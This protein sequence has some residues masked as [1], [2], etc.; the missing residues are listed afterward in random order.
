MS[1]R[2]SPQPPFGPPLDSPEPQPPSGPDSH[3]PQSPSEPKP[4]PEC[5]PQPPSEPPPP[6]T[7][8]ST[9]SGHR[10]SINHSPPEPTSEPVHGTPS[11]TR[12]ANQP[13]SSFTPIAPPCDP[14]R[15]PPVG[16]AIDVQ[17][18]H[19]SGPPT[20]PRSQRSAGS[21]VTTRSTA[22]R[23]LPTKL[24]ELDDSHCDPYFKAYNSRAIGDTPSIKLVHLNQATTENIFK[25][26]S[27][28]C[29]TCREFVHCRYIIHRL[30]RMSTD[31]V[32]PYVRPP[33]NSLFP[34]STRGNGSR[35]HGTKSGIAASKCKFAP[36]NIHQIGTYTSSLAGMTGRF[37]E[38]M[39]SITNSWE[40]NVRHHRGLLLLIYHVRFTLL[41]VITGKPT[42]VGCALTALCD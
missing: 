11:S 35:G 7:P 15:G 12:S 42:G 5:S 8:S 13:S 39:E 18:A 30:C 17:V 24:S 26:N 22:W 1:T 6:N 28:E 27:V 31:Q 20:L 19:Q 9:R 40:D 2:S 23:D 16:H 41:T 33:H 34:M 21:G 25:H 32:R 14:P 37:K 36:S 3:E 10:Y 38:I 29:P 4:P